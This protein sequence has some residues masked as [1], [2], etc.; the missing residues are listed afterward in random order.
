LYNPA[1]KN[2]KKK[3]PFRSFNNNNYYFSLYSKFTKYDNVIITSCSIKEITFSSLYKEYHFNAARFTI[4]DAELG[5]DSL[6][7]YDPV[8]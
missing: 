7:S 6:A 3:M 2:K 5:E 8:E 4:T 1:Q